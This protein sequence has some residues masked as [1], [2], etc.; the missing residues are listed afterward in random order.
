MVK[1]VVLRVSTAE[2]PRNKKEHTWSII[3]RTPVYL[4]E[5]FYRG[6]DLNLHALQ[7]LVLSQACLPVPSPRRGFLFWEKVLVSYGFQP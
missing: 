5:I 1:P 4:Q 6:Q 3:Y 2:L 7:H